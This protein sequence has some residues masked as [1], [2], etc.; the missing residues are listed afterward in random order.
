MLMNSVRS[1]C[2]NFVLLKAGGVDAVAAF[3]VA[4]IAFMLIVSIISSVQS[5]TTTV[6]SLCYGEEDGDISHRRRT[7][8]CGREF[9]PE[10]QAYFENSNNE[11]LTVDSPFSGN[12]PVRIDTVELSVPQTDGGTV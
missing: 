4:G 9:T 3:S 2:F 7:L 6:C 8:R 5:T 11:I 1:A 12:T 10:L